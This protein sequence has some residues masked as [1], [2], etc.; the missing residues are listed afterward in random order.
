MYLL[1]S[2]TFILAKH[3]VLCDR[4]KTVV[5]IKIGIYSESCQPQV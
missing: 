3:L 4:R 2:E 5:Y 1:Q